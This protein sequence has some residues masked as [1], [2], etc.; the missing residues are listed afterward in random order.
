MQVVPHHSPLALEEELLARIASAKSGDPL[1]PVLIIVPSR[2]LAAHV[3]RRLVERFGVVFGVEIFHHAALAGAILDATG[4]PPLE[5][6]APPLLDTLTAKVLREAGPGRLRDFVRGVPAASSSLLG[7]LTDLREAE[8]HPGQLE[9]SAGREHAELAAL[10]ARWVEAL[11]ALAARGA[12]D[13]VAVAASAADRAAVYATRFRAIVHHGAYELIGVHQRLVEGLDRGREVV[14]LL[15]SARPHDAPPLAAAV[16]LLDAQGSSAELQTAA[17]GALA[18]VAEGR[19]PHEVAVI[20]RSF[21]AYASAMD[22]LLDAGDPPWHTSYARPLRREPVAGAALAALAALAASAGDE[23]LGFERHA[24]TFE[25][26]AANAVG[27]DAWAG[28]AGRAVAALVASLGR[29]ESW[30]GDA[31]R[32][33]RSE[34]L[35]WLEG[36]IDA[37]SLPPEEADGA[38]PRILDAMQARGLTFGHV[39]LAGMNAGVFPRVGREDPFFR[40]VPRQRLSAAAARKLP[41]AAARPEEE[42]VLLSMAIGSVRDRLAVS[43]RRADETGR[44][45]VPSLAL[46]DIARAAGKGTDVDSFLGKRVELP[47]HPRSRLEVWGARDGLLRRDEETLLAAL[48]SE[49]G[50]DAARAVAKRRSELASGIALIESTDAF[51]PGTGAYDGRVGPGYVPD[52]LAAT[53]VDALGACPLRFFFR[54]VLRVHAPPEPPTPFERDKAAVGSRVHDVLKEVY[55]GLRARDAFGS[56][57]VIDR[58]NLARELLDA[59]WSAHAGD[60]DRERAQRYPVLEGIEHRH[61]LE[62]LG[63]FIAADLARLEQA[64]QIPERLESTLTGPLPGATRSRTVVAR[65]DRIVAG[66]GGQVVGDYKTGGRLDGRTTPQAILSGARLQVP[67]YSVLAAAPVE[68]LGVGP[69][70]VPHPGES[71]DPR[72]VRFDAYEDARLAGL[73]ETLGVLAGLAD[74]G[75]FPLRSGEHCAHCDYADACRRNHPPTEHRESVSADTADARDCWE[76]DGKHPMLADVRA[77]RTP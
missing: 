62:V 4:V 39:A 45:V 5:S 72:F 24:A 15:P 38:G 12:A 19:P 71:P 40:D 28:R 55:E 52:E 32:V 14:F 6:L 44:P 75:R 67:L 41:L 46:R 21:G 74:A 51:A 22:E 7:T 76:K 13:H 69:A 64:A 68:L 57:G 18:A 31:R 56:M 61:W 63:G 49:T 47:A 48:G 9:R 26:L 3:A 33:P 66:S 60:A 35:A 70:H 29:L 17:R 16:T 42:R 20:V 30:L 36:Q 58:T 77:A 10:Y 2:R 34:A 53:A 73:V 11:D 23:L 54:H 65:F 27:A 37:A 50:G 25:E 8:I 1:A 43:W 59:A